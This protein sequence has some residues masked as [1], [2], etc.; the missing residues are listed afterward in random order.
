M[1]WF[2][3]HCVDKW[4]QPGRSAEGP[5]TLGGKQRNSHRSSLDVI[6]ATILATHNRKFLSDW[7]SSTPNQREIKFV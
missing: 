3:F 7:S 5:G 4:T 6:L 1:T 2:T